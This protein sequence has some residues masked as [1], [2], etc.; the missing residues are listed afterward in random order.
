MNHIVKTFEEKTKEIKERGYYPNIPI[1]EGAAAEKNIVVNG[2]SYLLFSSNNYLGLS[3]HP[4]VKK[5]MKDAVDRYGLGSGGPRLFAGNT[6]IHNELEASVASFVGR[7]SAI[8]FV[9]GYMANVGTIP[10][11]TTVPIANAVDFAAQKLKTAKKSV[12]PWFGKHDMTILSDEKN[13]GSIVDGIRLAKANKIIYTH[14]NLSDLEKKL[15]G[16]K[17]GDTF[18]ISDGIFSMDG[19]I[20]PLPGVVELA[21][22]HNSLVMIDDAH[23]IGTIGP[24]GKGSLEHYNIRHEDVDI[25][26]GTFT[27]AFGGVGGFV[28]GTKEF[29]DFL[30]IS[31][32]TYMLSAPLP[33][34]IAAGLNKSVEIASREPWRREKAWDNAEYFRS[35]VHD[36][37]YSTGESETLIIPVIIG[38]ESKAIQATELLYEKGIIAPNARFPAVALNNARLR[39]VMTAMHEKD[40]IDYLLKSL[41]EIKSVLKI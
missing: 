36:I 33:P 16:V 31:A 21:K 13:H 3:S 12:L 35:R 30:R 7:E 10:A 40:E 26:L 9:A 37:G 34:S 20:A 41:A 38:D 2:K 15:N 18:I 29:I 32:R 5:T 11:M 14:K 1:V 6:D 28:A 4:D 22:K 17:R 27:K 25:L 39:F 24:S 23:G 19:D 8:T